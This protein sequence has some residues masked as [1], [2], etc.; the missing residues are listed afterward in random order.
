[1]GKID[2]NS[3]DAARSLTGGLKAKSR[4]RRES[5]KRLAASAAPPREAP[6]DLLPPLDLA[7]ALLE[8]LRIPARELRKLDPTHLREVA[9]SI[10]T[11]GFCAPILVGKANLVLD[12]AVRVQAA[13]L[14][15]LGRAP[16]I[17]IEYLSQMEQRVLRLAVNRLGEKG[18]WNLDELKIEFEELILADAPIEISGFALDEIDQIVLGEADDAI[19]RGL[20][21][22][23]LTLSP[24][25]A[26]AMFLRSD[27]TAS[28]VAARPTRRPSGS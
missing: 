17:R 8:D 19:E 6:N 25:P 10:S 1:M 27:R 5:L 24:S 18:E 13:R 26:R 16:C 2:R 20:S 11:F 14:L 9:N 12:G 28:S 23:S 7:Y 4:R 15:G 22:P 21:R 3:F